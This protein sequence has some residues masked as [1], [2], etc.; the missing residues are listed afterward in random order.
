MSLQPATLA[1][2]KDNAYCHA[3]C[4]AEWDAVRA[5][6]DFSVVP[7]GWAPLTPRPNADFDEMIEA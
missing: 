2:T 6:R 7:R 4:A 3:Q 5:G 1:F